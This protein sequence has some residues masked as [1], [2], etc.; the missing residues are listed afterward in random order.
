MCIDEVN[1]EDL[2]DIANHS[3]MVKSSSMTMDQKNKDFN[4]P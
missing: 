3:L 2:K 1:V 4:G